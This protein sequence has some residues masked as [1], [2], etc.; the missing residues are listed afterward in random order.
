VNDAG[1]DLQQRT[2][3]V[4]RARSVPLDDLEG[5]RVRRAAE[6]VPD[7]TYLAIGTDARQ[8]A[9]VRVDEEDL[10]A[11]GHVALARIEP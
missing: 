7:A 1:P 3:E 9:R 5:M 4:F 6:Y 8:S 11:S 2:A 10:E